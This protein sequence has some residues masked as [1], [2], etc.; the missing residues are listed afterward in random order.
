MDAL[1]GNARRASR[2]PVL[3]DAMRLGAT[4]FL[5]KTLPRVAAEMALHVL[6]YN[7]TRV[8]KKR[9]RQFVV[10]N[11]FPLQPLSLQPLNWS[12]TL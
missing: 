9:L 3:F 1:D 7:L 11:N 5:M 10:R 6:A 4:H 12:A 2:S 8:M